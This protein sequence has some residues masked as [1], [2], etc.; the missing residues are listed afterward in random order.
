[1]NFSRKYNIETIGISNTKYILNHIENYLIDKDFIITKKT[2]SKLNYQNKF[3]YWGTI[4]SLASFTKA[5]KIT[6]SKNKD[7]LI[8]KLIYTDYW[9]AIFF[10]IFGVLSYLFIP[11][12]YM[13]YMML[14]L[15]FI[16]IFVFRF[17][18]QK[19]IFRKIIEIM[20]ILSA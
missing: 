7:S 18:A 19:I 1:M 5:G 11:T 6:I 20:E 4:F 2:E 14:L 8:I 17:I 10:L 13:M 12:L 9:G 16:H 15:L 3:L